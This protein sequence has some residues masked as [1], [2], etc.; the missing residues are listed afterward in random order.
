MVQSVQDQTPSKQE[1]EAWIQKLLNCQVLTE[2]EIMRLFK[3]AKQVFAEEPNIV[4]VEAPV[5]VSRQL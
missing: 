5:T 3:Q 4:R 2:P 1:L